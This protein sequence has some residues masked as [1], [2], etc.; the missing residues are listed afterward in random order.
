MQ[1]FDVIY[2]Q[3][4][5]WFEALPAKFREWA[6]T[7]MS[8][9]ADGLLSGRGLLGSALDSIGNAI[10]SKLGFHSPPDD[11]PASDSDTWMPNMIGMFVDGINANSSRLQA[12][13]NGLALDMNVGMTGGVAAPSLTPR[14]G[15]GGSRPINVYVTYQGGRGDDI[16]KLAQAVGRAVSVVQA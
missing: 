4:K 3:M 8:M 12:A 2:T 15:G 10:T 13:V 7:A 16:E 5:A 11:G 14:V 9:F 6:L 1:G